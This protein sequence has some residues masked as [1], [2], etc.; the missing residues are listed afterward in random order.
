MHVCSRCIESNNDTG[1]LSVA[2]G[3]LMSTTVI[4]EGLRGTSNEK[5]G[6]G[7]GLWLVIP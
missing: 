2:S 3:D 5:E 7:V 6:K 4:V 1:I